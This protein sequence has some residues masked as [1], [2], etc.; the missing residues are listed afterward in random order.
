M[1]VETIAVHAGAGTEPHSG[2][3]A[4]A[5]HLSTTFEH[6]PAGEE[7]HGYGYIR[8]NSPTQARLEEAMQQLESGAAAVVFASGMAAGAAV[9]QSLGPGSHAIFPEDI[10]VDFRGLITAYG[11]KWGLEA[12]FVPTGS[13]EAIKAAVRR[14]T[15]LIWVETPSNPL[16]QITDI[17]AVADIAKTCGAQAAVDNTFATPMLQQPLSLGADVVVHATTKYC[18]GHNDVQGGVVILKHRDPLYDQ[19]LSARRFLGAVASPFAS[20]LVLRGLRTLH[21]RME[22]HCSNAAAIADALSRSCKV[23]TVYYPG[24]ET[25]P[26]N[27]IAVRQMSKFGGIISFLVKGGYEDAVRAASRVRLFTNATSLGGTE[28]LIEHRA[29]TEGKGTRTPPNLLRLS[30]GLEHHD[31]LIDDLL[32]ALS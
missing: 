32:T 24:L 4:P 25:H 18:G 14:Q 23:E 27:D 21:C 28:S 11:P 1:R 2:D 22:R 9:L 17:Q 3:I 30:A 26:G 15:K 20:W 31:D 16:L 10:Y 19:L 29:S 13:I 7:I 6:G 5:I 8:E 12:T